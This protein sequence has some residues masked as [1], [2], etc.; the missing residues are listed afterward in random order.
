MT[1]PN[2]RAFE[3]GVKKKNIF[4]D[5]F[6]CG[7]CVY[8]LK[9]KTDVRVIDIPD[10]IEGKPVSLIRRGAVPPETEVL[11]VPDTVQELEEGVFCY[12]KSLKVLSIPLDLC[13]DS[14]ELQAPCTII[15]REPSDIDM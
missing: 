11:S 9:I 10:Q 5:Y 1:D 2:G 12:A 8:L 7:N 3:R 14:A 15:H 13:L 4:F 6:E